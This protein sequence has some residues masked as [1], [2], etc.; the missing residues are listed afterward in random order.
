MTVADSI[1]ERASFAGIRQSPLMR[2]R[3]FFGLLAPALLLNL[4]ILAVLILKIHPTN[5]Q[6]PTRYSNLAGFTELGPW[7]AS[8]SLPVFAFAVTAVNSGLAALSYHRSRATGL[9]LL[10]GA[11]LVSLFTLIVAAGFAALAR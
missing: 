2:D 3:L 8:Y 11:L 1:R 6:V 10:M 4:I 5:I 9:L 7:Y